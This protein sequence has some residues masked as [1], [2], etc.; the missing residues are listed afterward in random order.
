MCLEGALL[1]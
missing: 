1:N